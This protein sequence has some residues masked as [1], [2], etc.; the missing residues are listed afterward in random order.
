MPPLTSAQQKADATASLCYCAAAATRSVHVFISKTSTVQSSFSYLTPF[1]KKQHSF[2]WMFSLIQE[3]KAQRWKEGETDRC[4]EG[5]A[6][7]MARVRNSRDFTTSAS[8]IVEATRGA[9]VHRSAS[10]WELTAWQERGASAVSAV[11]AGSCSA[12]HQ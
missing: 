9:T 8:P 1:S 11:G 4:L 5:L 7:L 3:A 2:L 10:G 6:A 12:L